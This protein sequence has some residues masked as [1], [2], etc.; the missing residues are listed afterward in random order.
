MVAAGAACLNAPR[1]NAQ[2][3][4]AG[5]AKLEFIAVLSRHGVRT[6]LQT[7]DQLNAYSVQPWPKWDVPVGDLTAQGAKAM[8][9]MGAYDRAYLAKAGLLGTNGCADAERFYFWSDTTKRDVE[10]G[11][12]LAAALFP[13][14]AVDIHTVAKGESDPLFDPIRVGLAKPDPQLAVAAISGRLGGDP[15]TLTEANRLGLEA[16][17]RVLLG[18]K[19]GDQC[20]P[21]GIKDKVK[22]L[23]FEQPA[24]V[25]PSR[26]YGADLSGPLNAA[27]GIAENF[28]LEY[29]DGK[30]DEDVGW[31]RA[32]KAALLQMLT[33]Q[34]A[35]N[36]YSLRTPYLASAN[37][38][39]LLSHMLRS[40]Q[41]AVQGAAVRG[42][43]GKPG[44]R[45]LFVL[46]HDS[47]VSHFG[48]L[49][50]ASW[51]LDGYQP[52]CRPPGGALVFEIWKDAGTGRRTVRTYFMSQSLD[53]MRYLTPLTLEA[54]PSRAAIFL[55]GCSA[56]AEGWPCDW[57]GFQ[58][59]VGAAIDPA[60]ISA[61][62]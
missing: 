62:K 2:P 38:S 5:G 35:Y 36:D 31:G 11:R 22:R 16:M 30:R 61:D 53:Q 10:S 54:P 23:L 39:N 29:T 9:L 56:A 21:A 45:A 57:E 41:Q 1:I 43:I 42:A 12:E 58:R 14:C 13:N 52:N 44:D 19:P 17:Q 48:S 25:R 15:R 7:N 28:L 33:L 32:D 24:E 8:R 55:P 49:L 20:P 47:D 27:A 40:M 26:S 3:S 34:E 6:P 4:G 18:C 46:G 60:F 59:V 51:A 50:K 37:S